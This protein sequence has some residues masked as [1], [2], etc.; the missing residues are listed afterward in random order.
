MSALDRAYER[1]RRIRIDDSSKLVMMSDCHRGDGSN[2]DDYIKNQNIAHYALTRYYQEGF[3]YIELGDGD[4]LWQNRCFEDITETHGNTFEVLK[5]FYDENRFFMLYGNHD[6]CKRHARWGKKHLE[7][8]MRKNEIIPLFPGIQV[9]EALLLEY[10]KPAQSLFALHGHQVDP[11]NNT[12]WRLA[13][14]LVRYAWRPLEMIGLKDPFSAPKNHSKKQ[15]LEERLS[16]WAFQHDMPIIAGHTHHSVFPG[17]N[18]ALYFNDGCCVHPR[19]I[20]ALEI[21]N[22]AIGLVKWSILTTADGHLYVDKSILEGPRP[23]REIFH[24]Y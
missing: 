7:S 16:D 24:T 9:Y 15:T 8:Y 21:A 4:E 13:R 19:C 2:A 20:T 11:L 12:F 18:D 14:F 22:G 5:K 17:K 10:H 1:A 3:T 6:M 23:L